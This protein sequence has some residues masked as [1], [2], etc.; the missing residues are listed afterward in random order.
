MSFDQGLKAF[1]IG[2]VNPDAIIEVLPPSTE[3]HDR[4]A[5]FR[6]YQQLPSVKE[7]ILVSQD[8]PVCERFVRQADGPWVLTVVTGLGGELA[9]T[10]VPVRIP[11]A[12]IYNGVEFT[13]EPARGAV[14]G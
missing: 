11:L 2:I 1:K 9:F 13:A 8:E 3:T 14:P 5:K 12:D 6:Q 4:G 10:T 7:Y